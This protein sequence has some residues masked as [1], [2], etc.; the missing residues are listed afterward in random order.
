VP[1]KI[2]VNQKL[3]SCI[4]RVA[5]KPNETYDL[6][7]TDPQESRVLY[8]SRGTGEN[9]LDLQI[10]APPE[11]LDD[12]DTFDVTCGVALVVRDNRN[13]YVTPEI[14]N[15]TF[16]MRLRES[17]LGTPGD[18][19]VRR[20]H[21]EEEKLSGSEHEFLL[22][23]RQLRATLDGA[24]TI[25]EGMVI[26][27]GAGSVVEG[28]GLLIENVGNP[29]GIG[30]A[31]VAGGSETRNVVENFLTHSWYGDATSAGGSSWGGSSAGGGC[32]GG[33]CDTNG[34]GWLRNLCSQV[35]CRDF[36]QSAWG[37]AAGEFADSILQSDQAFAGTIN[38]GTSRD[39]D[40]GANYWRGAV[41][42]SLARSDI[43]NSFI[44]SALYGCV[45]GMIYNAGKWQD[46]ECGYL[47]C[48]KEQAANGQS[49]AVCELGKS[50]KLCTQVV[51][52]IFELPFVRV[53][54]N[55]GEN[56][57]AI[58]SNLPSYLL[59]FFTNYACTSQNFVEA[60]QWATYACHAIKTVTNFI[61]AATTLKRAFNPQFNDNSIC[62]QALCK[63][64]EDCSDAKYDR[65]AQYTEQAQFLKKY[66]RITDEERRDTQKRKQEKETATSAKNTL[67]NAQQA[68]DADAWFYSTF[69]C[70]VGKTCSSKG[71][72]T[73]QYDGGKN[74]VVYTQEVYGAPA[75][76][77]STPPPFLSPTPVRG[78]LES[79]KQQRVEVK[80]GSLTQEQVA[81]WNNPATRPTLETAIASGKNPKNAQELGIFQAELDTRIA[82][83]DAQ[84]QAT[85]DTL[86]VHKRTCSGTS[87][88]A[89]CDD[90]KNDLRRDD[91][92][93]TDDGK[94]LLTKGDGRA[95][96]QG[97]ECKTQGTKLCINGRIYENNEE[98]TGTTA[99]KPKIATAS[100]ERDTRANVDASVAH[101]IA[102]ITQY[103]K[104]LKDNPKDKGKC[105]GAK[106]TLGANGIIVDG[107]KV[108]VATGESCTTGGDCIGGKRYE[109]IDTTTDE[110]KQ[111][112]KEAERTQRS[113]RLFDTFVGF[114][115]KWAWDKGYLD[116]LTLGGWGDWSSDLTTASNQYLTREG[117]E[118]SICNDI[119]F[120]INDNDE[121]AIYAT[122]VD[123]FPQPVGTFAAEVR[124]VEI[125]GK[126]QYLYLL[127]IFVTNPQRLPPPGRNAD[128]Y[129]REQTYRLDAAISG[130]KD[131]P[132]GP[133]ND[134]VDLIDGT[135]ALEFGTTFGDG[136][137]PKAALLT[138][139]GRYD[140]ICIS[141]DKNFPESNGHT[142]YCRAIKEDAYDRGSPAPP[143]AQAPAGNTRPTD[144]SGHGSGCLMGSVSG[145]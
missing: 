78:P 71:T 139:P 34:R 140:R 3:G 30:S 2:I 1:D 112:V 124:E 138:L 122:S 68:Y 46:I 10:R 102:L 106:N 97:E 116:K 70:P 29:F 90:L 69:M 74:Y 131:C 104:C 111:R 128:D 54:M 11:Q 108:S 125:G 117:W 63:E 98:L 73:L 113:L 105:D 47:L 83:K 52:E 130:L 60:H 19:F 37:G 5:G 79:T 87:K 109:T 126:K 110:G 61:D 67:T 35:N 80:D 4:A 82:E 13:V 51:G 38:G 141:F 96:N 27:S 99:D 56:I 143:Q 20:I 53:I 16:Q 92:Y 24:C 142:R 57:N 136:S 72:Y 89:N 94:Y 49:V 42:Q 145:C 127:T 93:V 81:L 85:F 88:P 115:T 48:L 7:S 77:S 121:G 95:P 39:T 91:I 21:D 123:A 65:L 58:I 118:Q 133:C 134:T 66:E 9:R 137:A 86:D 75:P 41:T 144:G 36:D 25:V 135:F 50:Y 22:N 103:Q 40:T 43:S 18:R 17:P 45:G 8:P 15:I 84:A 28:I 33:S 6:F 119:K 31:V 14:E 114:A 32:S 64:G 132:A 107:D 100:A 62:L 129:A 55:L 12:S 76:G 101:N 120:D 44:M 23:L 26:V 59:Q